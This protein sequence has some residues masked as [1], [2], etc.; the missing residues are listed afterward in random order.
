MK[1]DARVQS[2]ERGEGSECEDDLGPTLICTA[3]H[4]PLGRSKEI[5]FGLKE[6]RSQNRSPAR[7]GGGSLKAENGVV[8]NR[9]SKSWKAWRESRKERLKRRGARAWGAVEGGLFSAP[10]SQVQRL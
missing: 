5:H 10:F 1:G 8:R 3:S 6:S 4:G 2:G 7:V 9:G